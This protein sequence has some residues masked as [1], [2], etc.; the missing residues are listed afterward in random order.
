MTSTCNRYH[1]HQLG[2]KYNL[3]TEAKQHTLSCILVSI[4]AVPAGTVASNR[5]NT[6]DFTLVSPD[7]STFFSSTLSIEK[8][9][10]ATKWLLPFA[11]KVTP[12]AKAYNK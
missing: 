7:G 4:G 2:K 9:P 5:S 3:G 12:L 1:T 11:N 8:I 6:E 10:N